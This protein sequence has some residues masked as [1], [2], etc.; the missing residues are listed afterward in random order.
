MTTATTER[1][2][3]VRVGIS[4]CPNDVYAFAG[5]ILGETPFPA[6]LTF[7][8]EDVQ[9][10]NVAARRGEFDIVKI[11]YAAYRGVSAEYELLEAGGALGRGVGPLLLRN[12]AGVFDPS[13][14]VLVPGEFTTANFLLDFYADGQAPRKR[15]LPYDELYARL[16]NRPGTQGVVIHEAR[17]TYQRDG[18]M[19][20]Q[21][22]GE[23]WERKTGYAIPL[24]AILARR[25]SGLREAAE[26][27]IRESIAWADAHPEEAL[28][29]C[30]RHAQEMSDPVMRAHIDL[31]V[32]NYT[33]DLGEDGRA[34]VRFF[35]ERQKQT[36]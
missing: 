3:A 19:L 31:Y 30:R 26:R 8:Y 14:E 32:N 25:G 4:P 34:A 35:L 16:C 7:A 29:L 17:F 27:A 18:L 23:H 11:S 33:R 12:G 1:P 20:L 22:L 10:L 28:D 21:D 15:Y 36:R 6:P 24:G 2:P 13:A 5:L 9:T